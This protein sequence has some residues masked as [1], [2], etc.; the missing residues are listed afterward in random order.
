VQQALEQLYRQ[1]TLALYQRLSDELLTREARSQHVTVDKLLEEKVNAHTTPVTQDA[2]TQFLRDQ[3]GSAAGDPQR[4]QQATSYLNL[5]AR[6]DAKRQYVEG[7]FKRYDVH[8][9]LVPP[10][11]APAEEVRGP[12]DPS[13]GP[14]DAPVKV[15]VFSDYL[16]P[17]CRSLSRTLD[18][19]LERYPKDV[20]VIYRHFPL[21]PQADR[22]AQAAQCAQAQGHFATYNRA[23][24]ERTDITLE[25][26]RPLAED[27]GMDRAAF[28]SCLDSERFRTRVEEDLQEGN[29]LGIGGTPTLFVNGTRLEGNQSL[30]ALSARIEALRHNSRPYPLARTNFLE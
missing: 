19:L 26:L 25:A 27:L 14:A 21:H 13:M 2:I 22:L 12:E 18:S 28:S 15:V 1:R 11:P 9:S 6:A 7:L 17:Y 4:T 5:K 23:L 10:P 29:R 30:Q 24:F 8:V 20:R 3:T 16:C